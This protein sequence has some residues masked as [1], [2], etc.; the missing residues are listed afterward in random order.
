MP[1]RGR[2][3]G[4]D[5]LLPA[6]ARRQSHQSTTGSQ[7]RQALQEWLPSL[8]IHKADLLTM[9][10]RVFLAPP[11]LRKSETSQGRCHPNPT[12]TLSLA[13]CQ[14]ARRAATPTLQV[15]S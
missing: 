5:A 12:E 8:Q 14:P 9:A 11:S 15:P 2:H 10:S 1:G 3:V 7:T 4:V 13:S 6:S